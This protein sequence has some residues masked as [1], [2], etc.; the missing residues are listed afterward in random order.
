MKFKKLTTKQIGELFNS[1]PFCDE[2]YGYQEILDFVKKYYPPE[3][4]YKLVFCMDSEYNDNYYD[5]TLAYVAVYDRGNQEV[6]PLE[7]FQ[8]EAR[9]AAMGLF[10]YLPIK[11]TNGY[12]TYRNRVETFTKTP[13]IVLYLKEK[14]EL[15]MV[16]DE[17][18]SD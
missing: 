18:K 3:K 1:I 5:T 16:D 17:G 7:E 8:I 6:L 9:V 12:N 15:Y 13:N 11:G 14:P 2:N 10:D 4:P